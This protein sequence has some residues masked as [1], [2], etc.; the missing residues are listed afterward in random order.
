[1]DMLTY[2]KMTDELRRFDLLLKIAN[3]YYYKEDWENA[4][5]FYTRAE[6][7]QENDQWILF[8]K[9]GIY[10][11]TGRKKEALETLKKLKETNPNS[12]WIRQAEKNVK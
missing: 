1:M 6:K 4:F 11:N 12:F 7:L 8:R 9:I 10:L 2:P 3:I 5:N